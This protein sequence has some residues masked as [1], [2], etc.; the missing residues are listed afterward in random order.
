MD[1][2]EWKEILGQGFI[3]KVQKDLPTN[4][5]YALAYSVF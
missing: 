1:N 5:P 2:L 4:T 3:P